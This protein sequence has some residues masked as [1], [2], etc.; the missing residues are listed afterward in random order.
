MHPARR[1]RRCPG[2]R[3]RTA[4]IWCRGTCRVAKSPPAR[5][6]TKSARRQPQLLSALPQQPARRAKAKA[7]NGWLE[8]RKGEPPPPIPSGALGWS[9]TYSTGI[10]TTWA[11]SVNTTKYCRIHRRSCKRFAC[12]NKDRDGSNKQ[13]QPAG[14]VALGAGPVRCATVSTGPHCGQATSQKNHAPHAWRRCSTS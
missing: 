11:A 7:A 9:E 6:R 12:R 2:T 14:E 13:T 10:T 5:T 3:R 8:K 4:A 1:N